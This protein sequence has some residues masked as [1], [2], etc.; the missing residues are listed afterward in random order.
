LWLHH[1][2]SHKS[3]RDLDVY[4]ESN[5][6][7]IRGGFKEIGLYIGVKPE[8]IRDW[9]NAKHQNDLLA[10]YASIEERKKKG[11]QTVS[12]LFSLNVSD[13]NCRL[14]KEDAVLVD[15]RFRDSLINPVQE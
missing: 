11:G 6:V 2:A 9:F 7:F 5:R 4:P 15:Q 14:L 3:Q 8:T 10:R 13:Q 12:L 1:R